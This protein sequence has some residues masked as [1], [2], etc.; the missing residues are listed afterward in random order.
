MHEGCVMRRGLTI[1][2]G[3]SRINK[4]ML[5]SRL[6]RMR[7]VLVALTVVGLVAATLILALLVRS[8]LSIL[9]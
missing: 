8:L 6:Y 3:H 2:R 1:F 7:G 5:L 9:S 4:G